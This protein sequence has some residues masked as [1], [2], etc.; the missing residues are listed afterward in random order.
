MDDVKGRSFVSYK[1]NMVLL[2]YM[3]GKTYNYNS[4]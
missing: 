4:C 2:K 1:S 3:I